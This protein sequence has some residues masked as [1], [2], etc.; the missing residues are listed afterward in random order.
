MRSGDLVASQDCRGAVASIR[1]AAAV[2]VAEAPNVPNAYYACHS[3][4]QGRSYSLTPRDPAT[5]VGAIVVLAAVGG[6]AAW[7]PARRAA[8]LDPAVLL[9]EA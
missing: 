2:V 7:L 1:P 3:R 9:R 8:R 5:M 4:D 6:L